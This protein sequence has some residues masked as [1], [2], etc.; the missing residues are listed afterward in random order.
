MTPGTGP[1]PGSG[2]APRFSVIASPHR[3]QP[4]RTAE[5]QKLA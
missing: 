2:N 5:A 4:D 3:F 1:P